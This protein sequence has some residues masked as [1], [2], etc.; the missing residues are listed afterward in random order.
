MDRWKALDD[1]RRVEMPWVVA[2]AV[3]DI[4]DSPSEHQQLLLRDLV[5][6]AWPS[7]VAQ[8]Q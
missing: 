5:C 4:D 2:L 8:D 1:G 7:R 6:A 3:S